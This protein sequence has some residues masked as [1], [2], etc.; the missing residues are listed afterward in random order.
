MLDSTVDKHYE[1]N[2]QDVNAE[3]IE[4]E[5]IV[6]NVTTGVYYSLDGAGAYIWELLTSG[7]SVA[8]CVQAVMDRYQVPAEQVRADVTEI[9]SQ[10]IEEGLILVAEPRGSSYVN[11]TATHDD[12]EAYKLSLIH[13]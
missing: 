9:V 11:G 5:A 12:A 3:V 4:G 1:L 10:L 2:A 6:I 7:A 13:I 8:E